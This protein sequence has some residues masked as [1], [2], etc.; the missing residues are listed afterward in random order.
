MQKL[1]IAQMVCQQLQK[2]AQIMDLSQSLLKILQCPK[3]VLRVT[4]PVQKDDGSITCFTGFRCQYNDVRGPTKGGVRYHPDVSEDEVIALAAWMTWKCALVD[5]P[6]GGAKGGVIYN[7]SEFS[8]KELERLTRRYTTEI[9]PVLGPDKDIPAPDV[10]T[11]SK[12]MAWMMDTYSM[13]TGHTEPAIVTGKPEALGGS[14]GRKEATGRGVAIVTRELFKVL[15]KSLNGATVA[16]QG[17][18]NVGGYAALFLSQMGTKIVA[19]SDSSSAFVNSEGLNVPELMNW[20]EEHKCLIKYKG[21]SKQIDR[22][23]LLYQ[24]VDVL[25]PA[26]LE[27]QIRVDNAEKIEAKII[28]EGANGPTTPEAD[29]ILKKKNVYLI[30][31]ILANSGGVIVSHFEWVQALSG[32]YWEEQEVNERLEKKLIHSFQTVWQCSLEKKVSLRTAAYIIA[33]EKIAEV[34]RYRGLFP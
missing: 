30:P 34:Y 29:E 25:I 13:F 22:E 23:E 15:N 6:Y 17:F 3:R 4:F 20:V 33:L 18:G 11:T 28:S 24:D 2:A 31:D 10:F 16:I 27:N 21:K 26:A 1:S 7:P 32:L 19:V 9:M 14:K 5:L 12:T 8:E